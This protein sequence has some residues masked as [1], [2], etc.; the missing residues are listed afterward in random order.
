MNCMSFNM[1]KQNQN[2]SFEFDKFKKKFNM[3]QKDHLAF[4]KTC[5]MFNT[6]LLDKV[7]SWP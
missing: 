6:F 7:S 1:F 4:G 3:M 5:S 2:K